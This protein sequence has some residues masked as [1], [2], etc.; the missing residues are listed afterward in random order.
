MLRVGIIGAI[1]TAIC[2]FTPV[3]VWTLAAVGLTALTGYLDIL[4]LPLLAVFLVIAGV[5][6]WRRRQT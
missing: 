3:L 4:L 2:C 6:Y 5:G 1:V